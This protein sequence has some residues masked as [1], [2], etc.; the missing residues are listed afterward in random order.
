L[1]EL[2]CGRID[3]SRLIQMPVR[4][5]RFVLLLPN[6]DRPAAG[7]FGHQLLDEIRRLA[8]SQTDA[9]RVR[10]GVSVGVATVAMPAK[11]FSPSE[12]LESAERCLH[13]AQLSGGNTIKSIDVL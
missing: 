13:G 9:T 6:C 5:A 2:A 12:L 8:P 11:N 1:V 7:E 10:L 4:E 3:H